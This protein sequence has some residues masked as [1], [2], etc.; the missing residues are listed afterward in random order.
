VQTSAPSVVQT[1]APTRVSTTIH[2]PAPL[3]TSA[4]TRVQTSAP[5]RVSTT[6]HTPAPMSTTLPPNTVPNTVP[7]IVISPHIQIIIQNIKY[8]RKSSYHHV[9]NLFQKLKTYNEDYSIY[10]Q[11][12]LT[13]YRVEKHYDAILHSIQQLLRSENKHDNNEYIKNPPHF[14]Q[15]MQKLNQAI[16]HIEHSIKFIKGN[17]KYILLTILNNLKLQYKTD[18]QHILDK[19]NNHF[20]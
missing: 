3:Q 17:H 13:R 8:Y 15:S 14:I 2:T 9:D 18:T 12:L 16:E 4:P 6:I 1:S 19:W 10:R 7:N 11:L 20:S 5:A